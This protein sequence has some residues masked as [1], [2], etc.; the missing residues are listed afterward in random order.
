MNYKEMNYCEDCGSKMYNGR[1]TWCFEEY[2][3]YE[4]NDLSGDPVPIP[5]VIK[6]MNEKEALRRSIKE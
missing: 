4:Q 1:C 6:I 2:Y 5:N 3:I